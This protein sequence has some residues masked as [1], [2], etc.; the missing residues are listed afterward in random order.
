MAVP[1]LDIFGVESRVSVLFCGVLFY[2]FFLRNSCLEVFPEFFV[3]TMLFLDR[4]STF[5]FSFNKVPDFHFDFL[6][7]L[8]LRVFLEF[9]CAACSLFWLL[10]RL[11]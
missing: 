2:F 7:N 10:I 1:I 9:E 3:L 8:S 4:V 5:C 6:S 11:L